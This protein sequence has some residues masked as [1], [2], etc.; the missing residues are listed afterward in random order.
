M[1]LKK[2]L[3]NLLEARLSGTALVM[4]RFQPITIAHYNIIDMARRNFQQVYVVI[5][6]P[7][8][9]R[10]K[11]K[12]TMKGTIRIPAGRKMWEN[13][14]TARF[15]AKLIHAAF[16]GK[17]DFKNI[18][19]APTGYVPSV[20][21]KVYDAVSR[22][23]LKKKLAVFAGSDRADEYRQQL[24]NDLNI[25]A[26]TDVME[27]KRKMDDAENV[28]ASGVREA[29][30]NDNQDEFKRLTPTGIHSYYDDME[31]IMQA[32]PERPINDQ[33]NS[34]NRLRSIKII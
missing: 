17:L 18:I 9:M 5:V 15:R 16:E 23:Q 27:V 21:K 13:P 24:K 30:A 12:Y 28:S 19:T 14:F 26:A 29:I 33:N 4:G 31:K 22:E 34:N 10:A 2:L 8:P 25:L 20:M 7:G 6:D 11:K 1:N 32:L 3:N